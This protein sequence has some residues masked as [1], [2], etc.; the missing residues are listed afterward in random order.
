LYLLVTPAG[1][2]LWRFDYRF[3][4]KRKTLAIGPYPEISLLEA[5]KKLLEARTALQNNVD[6]GVKVKADKKL[7]SFKNIALEWYER[8]FTHLV[9]RTFN[10]CQIKA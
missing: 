6:P 10:N 2:K 3:E 1:G 8:I 7:N 9:R 5:R 4:G